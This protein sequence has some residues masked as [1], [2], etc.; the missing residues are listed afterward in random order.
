MAVGCRTSKYISFSFYFS[1]QTKP[2]PRRQAGRQFERRPYFLANSLSLRQMT[3][4]LGTSTLIMIALTRIYAPSLLLCFFILAHCLDP[5]HGDN[6]T[7]IDQSILACS[8]TFNVHSIP[9]SP[10]QSN[11]CHRHLRRPYCRQQAPH[12]TFCARL[13]FKRSSS[14]ELPLPA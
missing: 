11:T 8:H 13:T 7:D 14:L 12:L 6:K 2:Y 3:D 4:S 10:S 9:H 5:Q 1:I